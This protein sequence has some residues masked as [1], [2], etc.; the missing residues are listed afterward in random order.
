MSGSSTSELVSAV[1]T[2][3]GAI[4]A[5]ANA[6]ETISGVFELAGKVIYGAGYTTAFVIVFPVA[7]LIAAI[8][9]GNAL[10]RGMMDGSAAA[11][12]RAQG[13]FGY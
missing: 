9:K 2:V 1:S 10:M 11:Q 3:P 4:D 6:P 13:M 5:V 7:L 8:P 12:N